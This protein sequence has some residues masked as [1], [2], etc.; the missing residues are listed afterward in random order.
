LPFVRHSYEFIRSR[1]GGTIVGR[2]LSTVAH[3]S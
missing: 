1:E 3:G 2:F